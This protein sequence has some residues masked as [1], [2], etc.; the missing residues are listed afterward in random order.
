VDGV[1]DESLPMAL[2]G[3]EQGA[4]V[5]VAGS[6]MVSYYE[7]RPYYELIVRQVEAFAPAVAED[8]EMPY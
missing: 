2:N 3:F 6:L 5:T 8:D 4:L 7:D 1:F